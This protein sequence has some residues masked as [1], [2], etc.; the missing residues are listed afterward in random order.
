V[1]PAALRKER[2][3]FPSKTT[4]GSGVFGFGR[5]PRFFIIRNK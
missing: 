5:G 1:Y 2:I 3:R 4:E